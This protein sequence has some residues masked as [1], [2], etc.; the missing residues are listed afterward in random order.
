MKP[1]RKHAAPWIVLRLAPLAVACMAA[2][3][4]AHAQ[5]TTTASGQQAQPAADDAP[6]ASPDPAAATAQAAP[7]QSDEVQ[8]IDAVVVTGQLAALRR[9]QAIKQ[10]APGVVDAISAEEA[11]KFPDQNV[12]DSLQRVP[13]ISVNRSGGESSQVTVRGLGPQFVNVLINGR[14]I[15]SDSGDRAFNFDTLPSELISTAEVYKTSAADIVDGGI[16]GTIN[17]KTARPLD[18]KGFHFA[19]SL[20]GTNDSVEG[21]L[22]GDLTPKGSFVVSDTNADGTFGWLVS[23]MYSKRKHRSYQLTQQGWYV[24][25]D[26]DLDKDGTVDVE[27]VS[28]PETTIGNLTDETSVRKGVNAAIDWAPTDALE[29]Q[30]DAMMSNYQSDSLEHGLGLYGNAGDITAIEVD[31]NGTATGYTR[32]DTGVMATDYTLGLG[33]R[34]AKVLQTGLN[35]AYDITDSTKL[36]LDIARSKSWNK[37]DYGAGYLVVGTRNI[38][39]TPRWTNPGGTA[40]SRTTTTT[41]SRPQTT[42]AT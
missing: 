42:P 4:A 24:D 33:V 17:I 35:I 34:D 5:T 29:V 40:S 19:G 41:S 10:N 1:T 7:P 37:F 26:L 14:S 6:P 31:E 38:G 11:G 30:V 32:D 15:V 22:D 20:S 16:G 25:Q 12:A 27:D 2:C 28:I 36:E 21:G 3:P 8:D 18:N 39:F 9:A 13:G 23:G